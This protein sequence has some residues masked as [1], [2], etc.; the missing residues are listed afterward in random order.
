[1]CTDHNGL[2]EPRP[3]YSKSHHY[4]LKTPAHPKLCRVSHTLE[5]CATYNTYTDYA[6]CFLFLLLPGFVPVM[7]SVTTVRCFKRGPDGSPL[8]FILLAVLIGIVGTFP[9]LNPPCIL[10]VPRFPGHAVYIFTI[11]QI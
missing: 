10:P 4:G 3:F 1:M 7:Y 11:P 2:N 6:L 8:Y 5:K 9:K